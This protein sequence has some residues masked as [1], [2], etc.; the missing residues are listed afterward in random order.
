MEETRE[1]DE[2]AG[3]D[4]LDLALNVNFAKCFALCSLKERA[5]F[6]CKKLNAI[7]TLLKK[8]AAVI[9]ADK[10]GCIGVRFKSKFF[11]DEAKVYVWLI[12]VNG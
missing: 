4:V 2:W 8:F 3:W 10:P 7:W 5:G 11:A 6:R 12:A 1:F 9:L